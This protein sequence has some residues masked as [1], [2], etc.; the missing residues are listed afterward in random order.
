MGMQGGIAQLKELPNLFGH[1]LIVKRIRGDETAKVC[2][3]P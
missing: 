1:G 3:W 2:L